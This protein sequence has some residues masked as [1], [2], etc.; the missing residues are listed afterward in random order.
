M[1]GGEQ[2]VFVG[3]ALV[4]K[5]G[6]TLVHAGAYTLR[7]KADLGY[8]DGDPLTSGLVPKHKGASV[9]WGGHCSSPIRG[10]RPAHELSV[11]VERGDVGTSG[12]CR[13]HR[14][15]GTSE[16]RTGTSGIAQ[17]AASQNLSA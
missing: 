13:E 11:G 8:D 9:Q 10:L 7:D 17:R 16:K 2:D 1:R 12:T 6:Q 4:R 3:P 14:H 15:G 5:L